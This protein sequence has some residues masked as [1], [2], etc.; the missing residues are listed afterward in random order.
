LSAGLVQ[1]AAYTAFYIE[2]KNASLTHAYVHIYVNYLKYKCS[3]GKPLDKRHL[4]DI[5][6]D[7]MIILK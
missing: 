1:T 2:S 3:V 5:S 4:E 6:V 7:G